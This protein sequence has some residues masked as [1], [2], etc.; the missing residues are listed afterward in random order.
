LLNENMQT[1]IGIT[2]PYGQTKFMIEQILQD[3]C[4]ANPKFSA[5]ILRYF[6]PVGAHSSGLIGED[7]NG[8]PNN[9][10]PIIMKVAKGEIPELSVFGDDYDTRDG[11]CIRDYIHVMDLAKGH[12]AAMEHAGVG[13]SIYNLGTGNGTSVLEMIQ[14]FEKAS[15]KKLPYKIVE[16]RTGDLPQ[17]L[18]N[19]A[20]ANDELKW[21]ANLTIEDMMNDT[22]KFLNF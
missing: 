4:V 15:G 6:N 19:P 2:N 10:M 5:I 22:L 11:T 3:V 18:A 21:H 14:A 17:L 1:G 16:R 8:K 13:A 9:L 20:K 12:L 7:P